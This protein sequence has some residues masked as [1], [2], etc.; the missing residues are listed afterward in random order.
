MNAI[1]DTTTEQTF[2][3][4][5]PCIASSA[6]YADLSIS[7]WTGIKLDK[8][9]TRQTLTANGADSEMGNFRKKLLGDC[10]E[11]TA[12]QKYAANT[13]N[14]HYGSSMPWGMMGQRLLPTTIL[15]DYIYQ[16]T[17]HEREF[18]RLIGNLDL[19]TQTVADKT[20]RTV[21]KIVQNIAAAVFLPI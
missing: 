1:V 4:S 10:A 9:A 17:E 14:W 20:N 11:L 15:P 3:V 5:A 7:V 2:E 19:L 21:V 18:G 8:A 6:V 13:R 12:V 16:I